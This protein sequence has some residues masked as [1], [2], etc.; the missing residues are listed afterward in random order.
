M[1]EFL[2]FAKINSLIF[3]LFAITLAIMYGVYSIFYIFSVRILRNTLKTQ[4]NFL[5]VVFGFVQLVLSV[6]L[7]ITAVI[8]FL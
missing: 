7:I 4:I 2:D 1:V 6:L 5:F 8:L 3:N